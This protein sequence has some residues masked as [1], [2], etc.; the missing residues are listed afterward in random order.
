MLFPQLLAPQKNAPAFSQFQQARRLLQTNS[1]A[2]G[3]GKSKTG[4]RAYTKFRTQPETDQTCFLRNTR[5]SGKTRMGPEKTCVF[6][7]EQAFSGRAG[8]FPEKQA[9]I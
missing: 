6:P 7:E 3:R 5:V 8:M 9:C 4:T 1:S 2:F